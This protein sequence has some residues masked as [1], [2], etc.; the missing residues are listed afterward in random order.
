MNV[1]SYAYA[2]LTSVLGMGIV[3]FFLIVLSI[4]MIVIRAVFDAPPNRGKQGVALGNTGGAAAGGGSTGATGTGSH[5]SGG[6]TVTDSHGIPRWV[7][8]AALAYVAAEEDEY[9]P[10]AEAWTKRGNR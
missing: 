5:T 6:A 3:F 7:V 9:S 4:L 10:H 8:A 1:E 2:V